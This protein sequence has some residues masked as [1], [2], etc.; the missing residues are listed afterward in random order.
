MGLQVYPVLSKQG[1]P[2]YLSQSLGLHF[3]HSNGGEGPGRGVTKGDW[4][5]GRRLGKKGRGVG[6]GHL[7]SDE[8]SEEGGRGTRE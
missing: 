6:K 1:F 5:G 3:P 8:T 4:V 7:R 2:E